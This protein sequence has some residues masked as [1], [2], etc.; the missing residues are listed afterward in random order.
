MIPLQRKK[1]QFGSNVQI[2]VQALSD[3]GVHS[4]KRSKGETVTC[5]D[6]GT[7]KKD[8]QNGYTTSIEMKIMKM[9]LNSLG[10]KHAGKKKTAREE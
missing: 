2:S 5:P 7:R 10:S 8:H 1:I 3:G 4:L 6:P 9:K